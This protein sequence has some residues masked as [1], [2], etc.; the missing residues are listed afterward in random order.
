[1]DSFMIDVTDIE[2]KVNDDVYIWDLGKY[3]TARVQRDE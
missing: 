3:E 1:M 2:C